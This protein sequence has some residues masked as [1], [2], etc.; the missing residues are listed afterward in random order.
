M[1]EF[2]KDNLLTFA[3]LPFSRVTAW[4][5]IR[6]GKLRCYRIKRRIFFDPRHLEEFL[7]NCETQASFQ[8]TAITNRR[9]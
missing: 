4:R 3:D 1:A 6:R 9:K 8:N 5:L 7:Q 2:K